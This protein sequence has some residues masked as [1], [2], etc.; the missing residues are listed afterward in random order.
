MMTLSS[1]WRIAAAAALGP[2]AGLNR[3][4]RDPQAQL[5]ISR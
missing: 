2:D 5:T 1:W 4:Q 3:T